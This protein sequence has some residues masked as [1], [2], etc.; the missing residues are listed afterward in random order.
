MK[1]WQKWLLAIP[2]I[3]AFSLGLPALAAGKLWWFA[4]EMTSITSNR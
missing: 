3:L 4:D 1:T 2:F